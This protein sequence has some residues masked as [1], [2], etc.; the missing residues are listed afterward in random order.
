MHWLSERRKQQSW[1]AIE[2]VTRSIIETCRKNKKQR[3]ENEID[4]G[5]KRGEQRSVSKK[6]QR[7]Q[8]RQK[9]KKTLKL[10]LVENSGSSDKLDIGLK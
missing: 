2:R 8:K 9:M 4:C 5:D 6:K 7:Q 3:D 10:N 1:K